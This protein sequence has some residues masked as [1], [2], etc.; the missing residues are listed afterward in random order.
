MRTS[1]SFPFALC[2]LPLIDRFCAVSTDISSVKI[3]SFLFGFPLYSDLLTVCCVIAACGQESLYNRDGPG[4][5][6][7]LCS[8]GLL[9]KKA[10]GAQCFIMALGL[11]WDILTGLPWTPNCI[12]SLEPRGYCIFLPDVHFLTLNSPYGADASLNKLLL[13]LLTYFATYF[14]IISLLIYVKIY[15]HRIQ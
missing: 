9:N 10:S 11:F 1:F 14:I 15:C 3:F 6:Q 7:Y 12:G 8:M 4:R 5:I 2:S 13:L